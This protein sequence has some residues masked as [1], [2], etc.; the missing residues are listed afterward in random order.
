MEKFDG[1][2]LGDLME[3]DKDTIMLGDLTEEDKDTIKAFLSQSL[4]SY[5]G[6]VLK[7]CLPKEKNKEFA[8]H[9]LGLAHLPNVIKLLA[10]QV[11]WNDALSKITQVAK[12]KYGI[13]LTQNK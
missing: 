12:E 5:A 10:G 4:D 2:M 11:G 8:K 3:E 13:D 1:F 7:E 9:D 6:A